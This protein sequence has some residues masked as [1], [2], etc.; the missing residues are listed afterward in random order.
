MP[1][2]KSSTAGA[3]LHRKHRLSL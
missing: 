1:I 3:V 2:R